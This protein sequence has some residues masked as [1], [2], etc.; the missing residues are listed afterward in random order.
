VKIRSSSG[1]TP[2]GLVFVNN[3][4][5]PDSFRSFRTREL[6]VPS[7]VNPVPVNLGAP[8]CGDGLVNAPGEQCDP[9][10][11]ATCPGLCQPDCTCERAA[12]CGD[13]TVNQPTEQCDSPDDAACPGQCQDD[14]SCPQPF[15]GDGM[16]NQ[17]VEQCDPPDDSACPGGCAPDCTCD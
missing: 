7:V 1:F 5:G 8:T 15:C 17:P 9:P 4:F 3:Q 12:T 2:T 10:N 11:D 13:G 16:V 6:C 14:C